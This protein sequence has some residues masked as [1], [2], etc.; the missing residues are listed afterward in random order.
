MSYRLLISIVFFSSIFGLKAQKIYYAPGNEDW[1]EKIPES[2][3][4]LLYSVYLMGDIKYP[5]PDN[6]NLK[7]LK[8]LLLKENNKSA[9]VVL[10]DILYPLGLRDSTD[11]HFYDDEKNLQLILNTFNN[12]EGEIIFIPGNH[13]WERGRKNGWK[14]LNNL[15]VYIERY[16]NKGNI[17]LPD[18]GCPGPIEIELTNDLTLIVFDSQWYFHKNEKPGADGECGFLHQDEIFI[19]IED[20][21]RRNR[22]KKVILASHHPLYS[23]GKH[24]GHFPASYN[25]FPLLEIKN[26]LYFPLPGFIYTGYRK[27]LGNIQDLAHPEYKTFKNTLL[28]IVSEYPNVIYAAGHEHNLQYFEKDSLHHIVSGSGGEGTYIAKRKKKSDFA[29]QYHGI[30]RLTFYDNGN[31]W[32]EFISAG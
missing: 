3:D 5:L 1:P 7:M 15:E 20:A 29:Y 2:P 14:Y 13:D 21:I 6:E 19:Q 11:K 25:L 22:D 16:L 30:S 8:N 32:L 4:E 10:G 27:Y 18:G 26:W 24:G 31:V 28:D 23:V 17:F 12:Y 9:V